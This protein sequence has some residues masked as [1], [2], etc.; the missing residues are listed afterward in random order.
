MD[1]HIPSAVALSVSLAISIAVALSVRGPH[2]RWA[3]VALAHL[4]VPSGNLIVG[5]II[6]F[7]VRENVMVRKATRH[8]ESPLVF[9]SAHSL[10]LAHPRSSRFWYRTPSVSTIWNGCG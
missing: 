7:A 5:A 8:S 1:R 10:T 4:S 3:E 6:G 9:Q 2:R